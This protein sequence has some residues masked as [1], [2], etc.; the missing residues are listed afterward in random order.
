MEINES[1][2]E[3]HYL[4]YL[5]GNLADEQSVQLLAFLA[6]HPDLRIDESPLPALDPE[7]TITLA[8]NYKDQLKQVFF[9]SEEIN[10]HTISQF[11]IAETEGLLSVSQQVELQFYLDQRPELLREQKLYTLAH[12][13][14]CTHTTYDHKHQLRKN[15]T[16]YFIPLFAAAASIVLVI[17]LL[18]TTNQKNTIVKHISPVKTTQKNEIKKK[19]PSV[20]K[21]KYIQSPYP[22]Q[23]TETREDTSET[24]KPSPAP[25]LFQEI[26]LTALPSPEAEKSE[27]VYLEEKQLKKEDSLLSQTSEIT[28]AHV[29]NDYP[30]AR[31]FSSMNNPIAPITNRISRAINRE[32]DFR[33]AKP[34]NN[35]SGGLYVK[36]GKISFSQRQY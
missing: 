34:Q 24:T 2:Y 6:Q 29:S 31:E 7:A 10:D 16:R 17:L 14:P 26:Q 8:E 23:T 18:P 12:L 25:I 28:V 13:T 21:D 36:I 4:D 30:I 32:I 5:E 9:Q 27:T 19:I 3:V 35:Q 33:T 15:S 1:N 20:N 22:Q 11:L